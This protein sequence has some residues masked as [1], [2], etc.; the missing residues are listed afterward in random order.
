MIEIDVREAD[1]DNVFD[2]LTFM[3]APRPVAWVS[4]LSKEGV[5]NLAPFSFF[6]AV[7]DEPPIVMLSISKRDNKR[8]DTAQNI[9][10]TG[11]FVV[12]LVSYDLIK[13]LEITA[14]PY[15]P[16]IS[17]VEVSQLTPVPSR[18]V[19]VPRIKESPGFLE[20]RLYSHMEIFDYDLILGEVLYMGV[21]SLNYKDIKLIGRIKE[22]YIWID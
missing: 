1:S 19:S 15:P 17:E 9:L 18:S 6:N 4:T 14:K 2:V 13:K 12:N 16:N 3:V 22:G 8:K 5:L 7:C 11:E 20:C 10:D 21:N